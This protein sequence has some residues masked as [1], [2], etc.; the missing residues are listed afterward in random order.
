MLEKNN[1]F[2]LDGNQF[3]VYF[4]TH[5]KND[6]LKKSIRILSDHAIS[7]IPISTK[8]III[9]NIHPYYTNKDEDEMVIFNN[10]DLLLEDNKIEFDYLKFDDENCCRISAKN[11]II[12]NFISSNTF[13]LG[14]R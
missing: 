2:Y 7:I 14:N 10:F 13:L 1:N 3:H 5:V 12:I 11:P 9:T 4:E 8:I 6:N